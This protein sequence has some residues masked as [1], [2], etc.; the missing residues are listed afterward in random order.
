M[1]RRPHLESFFFAQKPHVVTVFHG[2]VEECWVVNK[3]KLEVRIFLQSGGG[4]W[5][6]RS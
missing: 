5:D 3:G 6:F 2:C 4:H 1:E